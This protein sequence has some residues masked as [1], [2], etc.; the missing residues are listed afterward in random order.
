PRTVVRVSPIPPPD[1]NQALRRRGFAE[2]LRSRLAFRLQPLVEIGAD[3]SKQRFD[4]AVKE[5]I[6]ALH[7]LLLDHNALLGLQLVDQR[8]HIV[9]RN[10]G[11]LVPMNDE[12]RRRAGSEEREIVQ[13]CWRADRDKAFDFWTAHQKL[14]PYPGA[15]RKARDPA[16]LGLWIDRLRPVE[17]GR[18]IRQFALSVIER[19]L[20][21]ADPAKIE[22]EGGEATMH[23]GITELVGDRGIHCPAELRVRMKDDCD[24]R[25]LLPRGVVAALDASGGAGK[26]NLWHC[27]KPR[28][29]S[30]VRRRDFVALRGP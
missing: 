1:T 29:Y 2:L 4:L 20:A 24:R 27:S 15:E 8:R 26:N 25:V 18:G 11:V 14:H 17:R 23:K 28:T 10:D 5:M 13:I 30:P 19:A 9:V 12:P 22:P 6:G 16:A 7:N 21:A 3:R